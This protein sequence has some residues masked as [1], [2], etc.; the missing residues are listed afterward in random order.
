[1]D[2]WK[3]ASTGTRWPAAGCAPPTRNRLHPLATDRLR[4]GTVRRDA[5]L[6]GQWATGSDQPAGLHHVCAR[7][8]AAG[9]SAPGRQ[10][11]GRRSRIAGATHLVAWKEAIDRW[12]EQAG[13]NRGEGIAGSET[14]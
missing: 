3:R 14:R 8:G 2:T 12:L 9:R 5:V 7:S 11:R 13:P 4:T 6:R 10:G 1:V